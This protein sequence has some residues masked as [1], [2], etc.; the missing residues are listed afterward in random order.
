MYLDSYI[1]EL[2]LL[3]KEE[4]LRH[5]FLRCPFAKNCWLLIGVHVPARLRPQR[6]VRNIKR[7]LKAPF[8]MELIIIMCSSI[9]TE[10]NS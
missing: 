8:A 6:A 4:K 10:R 5:L 1:C 9:W 2:G 7:Q 3:Q